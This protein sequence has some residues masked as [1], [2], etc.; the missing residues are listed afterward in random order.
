MKTKVVLVL[1]L[2]FVAA[3]ATP[4][5]AGPRGLHHGQTH[6]PHHFGD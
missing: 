4:A 6:M 5:S 3:V 1:L 2:L